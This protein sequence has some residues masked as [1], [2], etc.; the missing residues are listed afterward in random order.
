[1][2]LHKPVAISHQPSAISHVEGL[3]LGD[4]SGLRTFGAVNDL[5]FHRLTFLE[6]TEPVA[7]NGRVVDEDVTASVALD[8]PVTFGVV[9]PLD[10]ACDTHRSLPACCDARERRFTEKREPKKKSRVLRPFPL[11]RQARPASN[12][13]IL[14]FFKYAKGFAECFRQDRDR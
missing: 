10:L 14:D 13:I 2:E 1:M 6:R 3:D 9:E 11:R 8:E 4:V 7:L 12:Q 5:E